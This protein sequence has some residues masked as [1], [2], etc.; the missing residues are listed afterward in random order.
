ME[1]KTILVIDDEELYRTIIGDFLE[2]EGY[3]VFTASDGRAGLEVFEN[4]NVDLVITDLRMPYVDGLEV[5]KDICSRYSHIPL[6]VISGEG[7][8]EEVSDALRAGAWDYILK[9]ITN[10][11][12]LALTL[13]KAFEKADLI[14]QN[15]EYKRDLEIKIEDRTRAL[16]NTNKRLKSVLSETVDA[17]CGMIEMRDPYI[18]GHHSRVATLSTLI[19]EEMALDED[20]I[21]GIEIAAQLHD[22]GMIYVPLDFLVRP[23]KLTE[24]EMKIIKKHPEVGYGILKRID[25]AWPVADIVY[26]HHERV[27]GSGYPRKLNGSEIRKEAMIISVSDVVEAMTFNRQYREEH[28]LERALSEIK[29]YRGVYYCNDCV[30]ACL[31]VFADRREKLDF[32]FNY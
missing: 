19:A 12:I 26:Q 10:L 30:D 14:L 28:S 5:L 20:E 13:M 31:K 9:P 23:S 1:K 18:A 2:D 7:M 21:F 8:A 16:S 4:N 27:D 11:D 24:D 17:L 6:I 25:F 22:I 15:A 32:F 29:K 3:F